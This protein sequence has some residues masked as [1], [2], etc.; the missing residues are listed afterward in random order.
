MTGG[1]YASMAGRKDASPGEGRD[2]AHRISLPGVCVRKRD[3]SCSRLAAQT[4]RCRGQVGRSNF[5]KQHCELLALMCIYGIEL[6]ADNIAECR[7]NMFSNSY[8]YESGWFF[9]VEDRF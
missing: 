2:R 9:I 7:A 5:E 1:V 6:L 4:S 8:K 3:F